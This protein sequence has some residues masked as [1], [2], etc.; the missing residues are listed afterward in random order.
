M[1]LKAVCCK[2][3]KPVLQ[4]RGK[5]GHGDYM[6]VIKSHEHVRPNESESRVNMDTAWD[7]HLLAEMEEDNKTDIRVCCMSCGKVTG[8]Q[9][10]DAPGMPEVGIYH[11]I[12]TWNGD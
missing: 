2:D 12:K 1:E 6:D 11:T 4:T 7:L 9:R 5:M 3:S 8:W 10:R